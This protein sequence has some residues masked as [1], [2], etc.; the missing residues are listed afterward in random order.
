[1]NGY[2]IACIMLSPLLWLG[3][4]SMG[5]SIIGSLMGF[6]AMFATIYALLSLVSWGFA[7]AYR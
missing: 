5:E 3:Y 2:D 6:G 7:R 4:S 1:M